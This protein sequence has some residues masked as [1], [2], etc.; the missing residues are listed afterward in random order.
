MLFLLADYGELNEIVPPLPRMNFFAFVIPLKEDSASPADQ[1]KT[2]ISFTGTVFLNV[3]IG[4]DGTVQ[5]L[6]MVRSVNPELDKKAEERVARWKFA[7]ARK[8]GLP[9]PSIMPV[10]VTFIRQ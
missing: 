8:K 1:A 4:I 7:P 2:N 5:Q 3:L 6:K 9:V 10:Q